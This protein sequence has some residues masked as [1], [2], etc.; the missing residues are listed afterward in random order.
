MRLALS[1]SGRPAW[2]SRGSSK[3]GPR[4]AGL[5]VASL[6]AGAALLDAAPARGQ[7]PTTFITNTGQGSGGTAGSST[8]GTG[9]A[10]TTGSTS[11]GYVLSSI[12]VVS[13]DPEGHG[14]SVTLYT[15]NGSG[16]PDDLVAELTPPD[17]F[18]AG[19]LTF[20]AP[21]PALAASTTYVAVARVAVASNSVTYNTTTSNS[22]DSGGSSGWSIA[23][24]F[25]WSSNGSTWNHTSSGKSLRIAVKGFA[26]ND[27][28]P[29]GPAAPLVKPVAGS[30]DT[31]SVDWTAPGNTGRPAITGYDVQYREAGTTNWLDG[32]QNVSGLTATLTGLN[33]VTHE[34][35]V[36]ATNSNGDGA[37]SRSLRCSYRHLPRAF[38]PTTRWSPR[39]SA[40]A[41]PSAS[42]T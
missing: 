37:W 17:S 26:P 23:N 9:L 21:N 2:S 41:T 6:A 31:L 7:T 3:R 12:D 24:A 35:R 15:A 28:P 27:A 38:P 40:P 4:L 13:A 8:G 10:F 18:A 39:A 5:V 16:Y 20:T 25:I 30:H 14:F 32:P 42:C 34:V 29:A 36:R 1:V 19:T 33:D 11:G 22:E